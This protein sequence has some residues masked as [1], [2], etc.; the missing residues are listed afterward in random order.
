MPLDSAE[1]TPDWYLAWAK[2]GYSQYTEGYCSIGST[3]MLPFGRTISELRAFARGMQS[4]KMYQDVLDP[5]DPVINKGKALMGIS[6]E[7]HMILPKTLD[8]AKERILMLPYEIQTRGTDSILAGRRSKAIGMMK[9]AVSPLRELSP[10]KEETYGMEKPSDVDDFVA[11][12]LL[13][14]EEEMKI[15]DASDITEKSSGNDVIDGMI[16]GDL[17]ELGVGIKEVCVDGEENVYYKYVDPDTAVY[18]R[19]MYPDNRDMWYFG[20]WQDVSISQL[21]DESGFSETILEEIAN[22]STKRELSDRSL[23]S[24]EHQKRQNSNESPRIRIFKM[25]WVAGE[26]ED[27]M[28]GVHRKSSGRIF[29]KKPNNYEPRPH[30]QTEVQRVGVHY[31]YE[32]CWVV[33]T[34]HVYGYKK[35]DKQARIGRNCL[36]PVVV[37]QLSKPSMCERCIPVVNDIQIEMH[38]IKNML[39]KLPPAPRLAYDKSLLAMATDVKSGRNKMTESIEN[40][41]RTGGLEYASKNEFGDNTGSNRPP[42]TPIELNIAQELM[43]RMNR[44]EI[45][46]NELRDISGINEA[47]DGSIKQQDMLVGVMENME[48]AATMVLAPYARARKD[49]M[50]RAARVAI[51]K[52]QMIGRNGKTI[53]A[54]SGSYPMTVKLDSSI[55]NYEFDVNIVAL[56]TKQ[57]KEFLLQTIFMNRQSQTLTEGD[58]LIIYNMI[59]DGDLK[60]A[61]FY[62]IK[63]I[64]RNRA[65][66]QMQQQQ[67]IQLQGQMTAQAGMAVEQEKQKS[68]ASQGQLDQQKTMMQ[69]KADAF[70][71]DLKNKHKKEQI[72]L[73]KTMERNNNKELQQ[74]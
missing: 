48:A 21:R 42:I 8:I 44:I 37:Y 46:K 3:G 32:A 14:L 63:A 4:S 67:N 36:F 65:I 74:S 70:L 26:A 61:Q 30:S 69:A 2:F 11:M 40:F 47:A 5:R 60:K 28:V 27:Y 72:S 12:G 64:E 17:I 18:P 59:Q 34:D 56:P 55:S 53:S 58:Y 1:R 31:L 54:Y 20:R 29:Q 25:W 7:N 22:I 33:G 43:T 50:A 39:A 66:Q 6:W 35:S 41:F 38:S 68:M 24:V 45:L 51:K 16:T 9:A 57:E 73:E 62:T 10:V 19:S 13:V 52:W 49:I 15:K 23:G 71:E